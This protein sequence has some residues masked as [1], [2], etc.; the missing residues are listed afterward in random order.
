M[1]WI[2]MYQEATWNMSPNLLMLQCIGNISNYPT[3]WGFQLFHAFFILQIVR[4]MYRSMIFLS[5]HRQIK[6]NNCVTR[7]NGFVCMEKISFFR[8]MK[9]RKINLFLFKDSQK[10]NNDCN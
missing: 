9:I 2:N 7:H 5:G 1:K 3:K 10:Y 8:N 6:V 4:A